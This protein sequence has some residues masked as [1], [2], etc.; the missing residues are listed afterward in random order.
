MSSLCVE[1]SFEETP[2][3]IWL[4]RNILY[5]DVGG[6]LKTKI[7]IQSNAIEN[8]TNKYNLNHNTFINNDFKHYSNIFNTDD[9]T[10]V[11]K[12]VLMVPVVSNLLVVT[13]KEKVR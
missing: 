9:L 11:N 2:A 5:T 3:L 4:I 8:N 6:L 13:I 7:D 1:N 12:W 10:A